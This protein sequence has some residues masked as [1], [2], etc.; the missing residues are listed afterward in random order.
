MRRVLMLSPHFPP[1]TSAGTHRVRL[2]AP[3]LIKYG[4]E[5]TVVS[6]EPSGYE[7]RVDPDLATLVPD[8]VRVVRVPAWNASVT[9]RIGIGDL[10]LRA[11][12]G[13]RRE[14]LRLMAE[15]RFDLV[16]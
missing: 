1:D 6:V 12:A 8:T 7:G 13:L 10:G 4:W 9:R 11:F 16:F 3:H 5:P 14:C 15:E 2:F